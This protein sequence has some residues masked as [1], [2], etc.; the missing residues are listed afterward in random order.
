MNFS[1]YLLA[2]HQDIQDKAR[3]EINEKIAKHNGSLS[4]EA[5]MEMEYLNQVFNG[6]FKEKKLLKELY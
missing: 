2:T 3:K 1:L 4:Y 5:L 6:K